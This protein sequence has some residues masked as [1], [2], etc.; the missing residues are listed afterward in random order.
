MKKAKVILSFVFLN[1][2]F[3]LLA[4]SASATQYYV[5]NV[6]GSDTNSGTSTSMAWK[7]IARVNSKMSQLVAGDIV[8]FKR[9]GTWT[10]RLT[11]SKSG[12]AGNP[13]TFNAYG[14]GN[15]PSIRNPTTASGYKKAIYLTAS[16]VVIENL[17]IRD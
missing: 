3:V 13:I 16:Y 8:S 2:L 5:D 7:T 10:D 17:M 1:C 15:K 9:G 12:V 11:I 4:S 14:A 6:G